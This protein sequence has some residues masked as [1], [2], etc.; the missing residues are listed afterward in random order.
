MR[1]RL[2]ESNRRLRECRR[3]LLV[4]Q[5]FFVACSIV[6]GVN[7]AK[8]HSSKLGSAPMSSCPAENRLTSYAPCSRFSQLW[9]FV[10]RGAA[11]ADHTLDNVPAALERAR[12]IHSH[13]M[14]LRLGVCR[15]FTP[16]P[17]NDK[18]IARTSL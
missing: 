15:D 8:A 1:V 12:A 5:E 4:K 14:G 2:I 18:R 9:R 10:E 13:L 17:D 6:T 7:R 3:V 11:A 16:S